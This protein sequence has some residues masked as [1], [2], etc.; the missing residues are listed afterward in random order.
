MGCRRP[1]A[2]GCVDSLSQDN[3]LGDFIVRGLDGSGGD[4][5]NATT[6]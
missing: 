6:E 5:A 3:P 1:R 4:A 2:L